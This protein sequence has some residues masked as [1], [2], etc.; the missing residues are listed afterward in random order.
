MKK[1]LIVVM[2]IFILVSGISLVSCKKQE[3]PKTEET[4]TQ[5]APPAEPAPA[6]APVAPEKAPESPKAPETGKK[7]PGY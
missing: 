2:S 7:A 1:F 4:V 6:P 5:P 3:A